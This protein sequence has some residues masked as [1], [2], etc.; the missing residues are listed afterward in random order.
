MSRIRSCGTRSEERLYCAARTIFSRRKIVRNAMGVLGTPDIYVPSLSLVLFM[1]GC[2]FHGCPI[3]GHIPRSNVAFWEKKIVRNKRRDARYRRKLRKQG[4]S[5]WRV[6]EHELKQADI[7]PVIRRLRMA[8]KRCTGNMKTQAA[9]RHLRKNDPIMRDLI[10]SVGAYNMQLERNGFRMLGRS[11]VWQQL[12]KGAADTIFSRVE[13]VLAPHPF[14]ADSIATLSSKKLCSL[15]LSSRKASYLIGLANDVRNGK[16]NLSGI[17]KLG[18]EAIINKL[19]Q[20][21]GIGRWTAQMY[22]I[23]C[24]GR[25]DILPYDDLGIKAAMQK[26]YGLTCLP[27]RAIMEEIAAPW[28][29]YASVACWYCWRGLK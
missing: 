18:D 28:R 20:I 22:L 21:R 8:L 2:F 14:C 12:S 1:D 13:A 26:F 15:G 7:T 6:W 29:P 27:D 19:V 5:V 17:G 24:L 16:I 4:L 11:I 10:S 3:H 9:V 23:F 25:P